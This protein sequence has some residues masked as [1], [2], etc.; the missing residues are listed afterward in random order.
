MPLR[1]Y[2]PRNLRMSLRNTVY[3]LYLYIFHFSGLF[4]AAIAES[5]S[6]LSPWAYQNVLPEVSHY[7]ASLMNP[8]FLK[9]KPTS[10][11]LLKYMK[12]LPAK[13]I[14]KASYFLNQ[15]V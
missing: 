10:S 2:I 9:K 11:Q 4:R 8:E 15:K 6:A 1:I 13:V 5:A 7:F 12:S 3:I 14:D